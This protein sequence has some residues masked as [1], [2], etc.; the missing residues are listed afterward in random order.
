VLTEKARVLLYW[1]VDIG[2]RGMVCK[3]FLV[4]NSTGV[5]V[6]LLRVT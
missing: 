5:R 2:Q 6:A 4:V 1:V 3:N